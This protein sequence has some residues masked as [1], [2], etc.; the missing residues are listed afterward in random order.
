MQD[1]G[2]ENG[3]STIKQE[4]KTYVSTGM[5]CNHLILNYLEIGLGRLVRL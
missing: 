5:C 1:W 4:S 2:L 3:T